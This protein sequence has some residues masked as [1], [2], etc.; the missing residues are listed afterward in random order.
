M[1]HDSVPASDSAAP[2]TSSAAESTRVFR[3]EKETLYVL[4]T[5]LGNLRDITLRAL[6]ILGSVDLILAEDTRVSAKLL[7]RYGIKAPLR[8]LHEHNECKS[9]SSIIDLLQ[10]GHSI[11]LISDAGTPAVSDPGARLVAAVRA[12]AL[13]VVPIPGPCALIA[14]ISAAGL[15]AEHFYFAGFLPVQSKARR[16][17]L[18]ILMETLRTLDTALVF[19]EAPHRI[20]HTISDLAH[21]FQEPRDLI[22]AREL[23]KTFETIQR[24]PLTDAVA[25]LDAH[26][27][28]ERGEL[29]LIVDTPATS[30]KNTTPRDTTLGDATLTRWL[31]A[32]L[33][34]LPPARAARV[35]AQATGLPRS[36][37]YDK[38]KSRRD[39]AD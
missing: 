10:Q 1:S 25:W 11:A 12:A 28:T 33:E 9:A 13:P 30:L 17:Q 4:A 24:T 31:P 21:A 34:E 18:E 7:A 3:A 16:A 36:V 22:I 35:A 5:P 8:A 39:S 38:I 20:R 32:L 23:T 29:V 37:I 27:D 14:A 19:Y 2:I 6:D 15:N 26:P